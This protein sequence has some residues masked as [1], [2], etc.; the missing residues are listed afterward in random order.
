MFPN[1]LGF[2][3]SSYILCMVVGVL[4]AV[5][6]AVLYLRRQKI[7]KGGLLDLFICACFAVVAGII[8]AVLFENLYE[9]I[10]SPT[11]YQ[12]QFKMTFFGGLLGGVCGF[13][14]VYFFLRK[15]T[16]L[17]IKSVVIIAPACITAAHCIGR[18]GCFLAGCCYGKVTDSWIGVEFPGVPGKRIPTQ[19]IEAIF[20]AILTAIL[21]YLAFK[22]DFK[23]TFIVYLGSYSIF[24]FIIEFFRDDERGVNG[25][26]SPSQIWC[27]VL[28]VFCIPLYFILRQLFKEKEN[29]KKQ[30][31]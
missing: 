6:I 3:D 2:P 31:I 1:I 21:L 19:L 11:G 9:V 25:T 23:Y 10:A 17:P 4:L 27:I 8:F 7:E 14:L 29:E 24:R 28:F 18:I 15:N 26:L 13:L 20:L 12:F 22:K 5:L 16:K 30:S